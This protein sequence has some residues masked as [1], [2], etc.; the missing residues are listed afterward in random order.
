[1]LLMPKMKTTLRAMIADLTPHPL[2]CS[3]KIPQILGR[4]LDL[5]LSPRIPQKLF[6]RWFLARIDFW[7]TSCREQLQGTLFRPTLRGLLMFSVLLLVLFGFL[8]DATTPAEDGSYSSSSCCCYCVRLA[9]FFLTI[10]TLT[11]LFSSMFYSPN[12]YFDLLFLLQSPCY[13]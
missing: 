12:K 3:R 9:A 6:I 13:S 5:R 1:M 8:V 2:S 10:I 11:M 4:I 7:R